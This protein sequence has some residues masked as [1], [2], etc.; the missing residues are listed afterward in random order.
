MFNIEMMFSF[1]VLYLGALKIILFCNHVYKQL[2]DKHKDQKKIL[3]N[4]LKNNREYNSAAT[5]DTTLFQLNVSYLEVK[6][7]VENNDQ[8]K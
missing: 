3:Y 7:N 5:L 8:K 2:K 6:I 4:R 1:V